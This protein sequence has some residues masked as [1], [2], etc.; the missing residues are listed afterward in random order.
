MYFVVVAVDSMSFCKIYS[1]LDDYYVIDI[2][3]DD[4]FDW[5][6]NKRK[7]EKY[8]RLFDFVVDTNGFTSFSLNILTSVYFYSIE[9]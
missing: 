3:I 6:K 8:N 9:P 1:E 2:F 4:D 5:K 7:H